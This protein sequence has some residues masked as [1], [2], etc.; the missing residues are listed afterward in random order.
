MVKGD[1][2]WR[3]EH[4][5]RRGN[6]TSS[7]ADGQGSKVARLKGMSTMHMIKNERVG[8]EDTEQGSS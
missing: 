7:R 6:K 2:H 3:G 1:G 5:R 4:R 8:F